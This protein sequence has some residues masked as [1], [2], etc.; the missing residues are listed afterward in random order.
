MCCVT[1]ECADCVFRWPG[2]SSTLATYT[3][4]RVPRG[5]G[6][7]KPSSR[8]ADRRACSSN[9]ETSRPLLGLVTLVTLQQGG[10]SRVRSSD[11]RAP[12]QR[13]LN[14]IYLETLNVVLERSSGSVLHRR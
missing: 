4:R 3:T 1:T 5:Q 6:D 7:R 9:G 2:A 12:R 11:R 8:V 14:P 13:Y 10:V